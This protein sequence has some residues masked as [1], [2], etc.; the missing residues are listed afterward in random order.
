MKFSK[1]FAVSRIGSSSMFNCRCD[2]GN[3]VSV[4]SSH[5]RHGIKKNCGCGKITIS[6]NAKKRKDRMSLYSIYNSMITRCENPNS[7]G[8]KYYGAKGVK[9]C[10]RWR[11]SYD[12]FYDDMAPRPSK[13]H[14]LDRIN[15]FGDYDPSNCRWATK[16]EQ[17]RNKRVLCQGHCS[18]CGKQ[19]NGSTPSQSCRNGLC[20]AC[21]EYKRRNGVMRP[22]K[23][24]DVIALSKSKLSKRMSIKVCKMNSLGQVIKTYNSS[25]EAANDHGVT[26]SAISNVLRGRSKTC[27]GFFWAYA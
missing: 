27:A 14:T 15:P 6:E 18:N 21:N 17:A 5:L 26:K 19:T 4:S 13:N 12:C 2:C 24:E 1:L 8:W 11:K 9:I 7:Q 3:T 23:T 20:P 10:Q 22:A 25:S 16:K